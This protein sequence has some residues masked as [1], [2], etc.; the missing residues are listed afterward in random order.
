MAQAA[1][2]QRFEQEL[3]IREYPQRVDRGLGKITKLAW[4]QHGVSLLYKERESRDRR[5]ISSRRLQEAG[6]PAMA[7]AFQASG[8]PHA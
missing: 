1:D 7:R 3:T 4:W 8:N 6:S 2:C 5:P